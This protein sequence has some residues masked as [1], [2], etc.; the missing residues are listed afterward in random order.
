MRWQLGGTRMNSGIDLSSHSRPLATRISGAQRQMNQFFNGT[1]RVSPRP[2]DRVTR[3]RALSAANTISN[4]P[5]GDQIGEKAPTV[6]RMYCINLNGI[7]LDKRGG[8]FETVCRCIKEIQA[9]IFSGQEHKL[10]TSQSEVRSIIYDTAPQHWERQRVVMGTTP[11]PFEKT[12]KP[13]GTMMITTGALTSRIKKQVRDKWG[14]WVCQEF[15]GKDTKQLVIMSAYQ[16]IDKGS[17]TGKITVAAQHLSLLIQS[18]DECTKPREAFRRDLLL[19][20]KEYQHAGFNILMT[21][22]FNEVLGSDFDGMSKI[23]N[24]AGLIDLMAKH[25]TS[26]PPATYSR[27]ATRIDYALASPSVSAALVSAGYEAFDTRIPSD[28]RGYFFDFDTSKLF[29]SETQELETRTRRILHTSNAK[30]VTEYIRQKH[31]LLLQCDAFNRTN[32]LSNPGNRHAFADRLD[33]DVLNASITAEKRIPKYDTPAWSVALIQARYYVTILTKQL[34]A[35]KTGMDHHNTLETA[36][37]LLPASAEISHSLPQT[38]AECSTRLRQAKQA[39][40]DLVKVSTERRDQELQ[41][42]I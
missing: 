7:I 14:R 13:G 27:G 22:D 42:R 16:P 8:K 24:E 39:V 36:L 20:V 21:G 26:P 40:K 5:W 6:T 4:E 12:H 29:G 10:D 35:L 18:Q 11:I 34:T 41:Q 17:H 33:T 30:Q 2:F 32:K 9:D 31:K 1:Q 37:K 3:S 38:I 19:C 23:A 15:Q 25:N 28:H